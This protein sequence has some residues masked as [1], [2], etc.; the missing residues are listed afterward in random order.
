LLDYFIQEALTKGQL[1]EEQASG[2]YNQ[3]QLDKDKIREQIDTYERENFSDGG[4]DFSG[5]SVPQLRLLYRRYTGVDGP[6]DSRQLIRELKRLIK[7]L[8]ED[9]IPFSEGGAVEREDFYKGSSLEPQLDKIK[10]LFLKGKTDR[11]IAEIIKQPRGTVSGAINS[12]KDGSAPVKISTTELSNRPAPVGSNIAKS[13]EATN[14]INKVYEE[15]TQKLGKPP[16]RSQLVEAANVVPGTIR[17]NTP[18]LKFTSEADAGA[19]ATAEMYKKQKVDKP[20]RTT[21]AGV[22]GA[23]FK[24]AA[25]EAEY[26]KFLELAAEYPKGSPKNP[27]DKKFFAKTFNMPETDVESIH[28]VVR[29]KY[30]IN[31]PKATDTSAGIRAAQLREKSDTGLEQEYTKLKKG[32]RIGN[33]DLAHRVSKKYNV[34]TANLGLD[35]PLINRVIVKPN[36]RDISKLY[37][38]RIKIENKYKLKDGTFKKPSNA[39]IK[40]LEK[41]NNDVETLARETKGRLSAVINDPTDLNKPYGSLGVDPSKTIG[42]GII[43]VDLKDVKKLSPEDQAFLKLNLLEL[44]K[45]E[46]NKTPK[47]IADEFKDVLSKPAVR[48]RIENIIGKGKMETPYIKQS[49]QILALSATPNLTTADQL[50]IPQKTKTRDM[51]KKAFTTGAKTA[52]KIIKPL[53]VGFGVNAVKTA[54]TKAEEQGLE[55]SNID[56]LMAFDSGDAEVA[57]NNARRRVDPVFAAQER[58]KDLAQMTDDFEEVGQSPFGK[59]NDQ[60]K[61]IKLP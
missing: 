35:N 13:Q 34:T 17:S 40:I 54:I 27:Y 29:E 38:Q 41:I 4:M 60:I 39:D 51:F 31:Y 3:L 45:R 57:L 32:E 1:T 55:L 16:T 15:L 46:L 61:N 42:G 58:A 10:E 7:G 6:S 30:N 28:K 19:K 36:E 23:K 21:Y 50:P 59:Y 22:K 14:R 11:E 47:M 48:K 26:K 5:L 20:T 53:G 18:N 49:K 12:M 44:K 56:K 37:D 2:I 43:D 25:Q 8:D 52:G 24:N 9:G 33:P